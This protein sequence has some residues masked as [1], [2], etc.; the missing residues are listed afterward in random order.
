V[1]ESGRAAS[2]GRLHPR[3]GDRYR[4][5]VREPLSGA[6]FFALYYLFLLLPIDW[7]STFGGMCGRL[8]WKYRYADEQQ[9]IRRLYAALSAGQPTA[10]EAE[11]AVKAVF[12]HIGR[13]GAEFATLHR[14]WRRGRIAVSG[15]EHLLSA[16]EGGRPVIVMGVHTGNW[17]VIGP[18][19]IGLGIRGARG[20]YQPLPNR[21][22]HRLLVLSRRRYGAILL[23]PGIAATRAAYRHLVEDRGVFLIY[24]DEERDGNVAA[25][26]L[27]RPLPAR[28]NIVTAV[29]L[30]WAS[31]AQ[32]V[33]AYVERLGGARFR[34][35]FLPPVEL[36][37][38]G[39]PGA[40]L[41][42]VQRLDRTITPIV[43]GRLDQWYMLTQ[44]RR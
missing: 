20:F 44:H 22:A 6:L 23:R 37:T 33:P 36:V 1:P 30:A 17:E 14:L 7:V 25:P 38:E 9:R 11:A 12:V 31:G 39:A 29:R 32:I 4:H 26:L 15:A 41:E 24:A 2:A 42:N 27:G 43:L 13:V 5:W 40:L 35:N 34:T 28:S 21:F 8:T 3:S 16:R 18:T 19:M 10:R